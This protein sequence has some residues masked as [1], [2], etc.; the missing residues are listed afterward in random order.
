MESWI[1]LLLPNLLKHCKNSLQPTHYCLPNLSC[2]GQQSVLWAR[3]EGHQASPCHL[4]E[5]QG[6]RWGAQKGEQLAAVYTC[7]VSTRNSAFRPGS[8]R[9]PTF[10]LKRIWARGP[11]KTEQSWGN[12]WEKSVKISI[13]YKVASILVYRAG[14]SINFY[15][16]SL[17][18]ARL[19]TFLTLLN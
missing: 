15:L 17:R 8:S 19:Q 7:C 3:G 2:E 6:Q 4:R 10:M 1:A 5:L 11:G 14:F 16:A 12:S 13:F 18:T 9:K